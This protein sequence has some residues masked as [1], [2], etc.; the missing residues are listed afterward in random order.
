[1]VRILMTSA[2]TPSSCRDTLVLLGCVLA[3][4]C[5]SYCKACAAVSLLVVVLSGLR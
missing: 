1:M 3:L 4:V 5:V 2:M